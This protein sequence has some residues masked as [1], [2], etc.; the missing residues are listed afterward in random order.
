MHEGSCKCSFILTFLSTL[1]FI[2]GP[3]ALS[4][5]FVFFWFHFTFAICFLW[6]SKVSVFRE[7]LFVLGILPPSW[8]KLFFRRSQG[9]SVQQ[10]LDL[11]AKLLTVS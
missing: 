3:V 4:L 11:P 8:W 10:T 5:L 7:L 1:L 6:G 9:F 2:L